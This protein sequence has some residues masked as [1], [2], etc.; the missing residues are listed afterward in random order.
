MPIRGVII[1]IVFTAGVILVACSRD[2][3]A[4]PATP[5]Q[6]FST[7]YG[8]VADCFA[9]TQVFGYGE[10]DIYV[11]STE[12]TPELPRHLKMFAA[13]PSRF[14]SN[15]E[16]WAEVRR[17]RDQFLELVKQKAS[18]AKRTRTDAN[19]NY[20][21]EGLASGKEYLVVARIPPAEDSEEDF[22]TKQTTKL[23]PGGTRIDL[24]GSDIPK[25]KCVAKNP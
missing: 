13:V 18:Q 14:P 12:Q 10:I 19:G 9:G 5:P 21:V 3:D 25:E 11:F 23:Q 8:E 17:L 4:A 6:Q 22:Q 24:W 7:V 15:T 1:L 16:R 2:S 20:R